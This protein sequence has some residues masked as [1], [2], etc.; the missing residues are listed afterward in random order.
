MTSKPRKRWLS[1]HITNDSARSSELPRGER[2]EIFNGKV[3]VATETI[4]PKGEKRDRQHHPE[5]DGIAHSQHR[6]E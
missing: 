6:A 5:S 3:L 1:F 4:Y 2:L